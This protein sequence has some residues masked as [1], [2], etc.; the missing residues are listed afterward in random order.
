M[1]A[2]E[3]RLHGHQVVDWMADYLAAPE[4]LPVLPNVAPG[5]LFDALPESAPD[6]GEPMERILEDFR[7]Q[8]LP[9]M[10]LWNHPG[11]MAYFATTADPAGILGEMLTSTLNV[12]CMLWKSCPAAAELEQ[13]TLDWLRQWMG[14]PEQF[15][16]IYDTASISTMHAIAAARHAIAPE[17]REEGAP[18]DL[19]LYTSEQ[20]HSSVERGAIAIGVGQRNVRKI[21]TDARFAMRVDLLDAVIAEDLARGLTPFC[22]VPTVGTTASTA[23]DPV[24]EV[25]Q[26]AG[27]R[28]LWMHV[29]A[30][31]G[32]AA[33]I[34]PEQ[35]GLLAGCEHADS[36]VVN[37][38]KW[39]GVPLDLSI[40]YTRRPEAL[41][42]AYSILPEYLKTADNP[43]AVN[44][45]DYGVQLGR[46]FRALK[47]WFV[48]RNLGRDGIAA[49]IREHMEAAREIARGIDADPQFELAAPVTLS[50]VCFR[51]TAGDEATERAMHAAN[52]TGEVFLSQ[53]MLDGKFVIRMAIGNHMTDRDRARK[54]WEVL[55]RVA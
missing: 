18:R 13:V 55:K 47:L 44:F 54:A 25:A 29:D 10:T 46:R 6:A 37:P 24:A 43:R 27:R 19:V 52:A 38:H 7:S 31:Y 34:V 5:A 21:G 20:A 8:I 12:N 45:M 30:A 17:S 28:G 39:M 41:R 26:V 48:M 33:A 15:G 11:F 22:V 3:F 16:I 36:L 53:A 35:S 4:R 40:L 42:G 2:E 14:L 1:T 51:M 49:R 50:L 23:I 9:S 32:G